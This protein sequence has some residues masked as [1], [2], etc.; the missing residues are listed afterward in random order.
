MLARVAESLYW[1]GRNI[2][3]C[4][5]CARYMQVQYFSTLEAPMS[6]N[7]DFTL[8]SILLNAI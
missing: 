3:R 5:H 1:I 7:K 8:R 6:H 2:E 4:E